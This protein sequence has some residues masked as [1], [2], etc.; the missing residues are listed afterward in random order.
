M[1]DALF[2]FTFTAFDSAFSHI[3]ILLRVAIV[4]VSMRF[5]VSC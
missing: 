1:I 3:Y 4:S 2:F 5:W